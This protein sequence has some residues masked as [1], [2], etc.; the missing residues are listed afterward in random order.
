M[1]KIVLILTI[2]LMG[3][4]LMNAQPQRHHGPRGQHATPEQMIEK[5]VAMLDEALSL[6]DAQK[7]EITKVFTEEM[8]AMKQARPEKG[9]MDKRQEAPDEAAKRAHFEQMKAQH[10]AT[11]A[12]IEALLTPEQAAKYAEIKKHDD[13]PGPGMRHEGRNGH[14][15]KSR[16]EGGCC[17]GE[18]CKDKK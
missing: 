18:C 11:D 6:T 7:G 12:K 5:R 17:N 8:E 1:K 16:H 4:M 15:M 10:E 2:A 14:G 13:K 9:E 3:T